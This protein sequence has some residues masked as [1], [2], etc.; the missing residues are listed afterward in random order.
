MKCKRYMRKCKCTLDD[1]CGVLE[2]MKNDCQYRERLLRAI[3]LD[4]RWNRM[5]YGKYHF[6]KR[7]CNFFI[8]SKSVFNW[9][10]YTF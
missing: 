9:D 3:I 4:V 2:G 8:S 7:N 10:T 1:M 5:G 6:E